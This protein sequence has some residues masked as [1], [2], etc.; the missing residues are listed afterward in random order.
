MTLFNFGLVHRGRVNFHSEPGKS[1]LLK[2][3]ALIDLRHSRAKSQSFG[4]AAQLRFEQ[5]SPS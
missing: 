1:H 2:R 3:G 4:H 5:F